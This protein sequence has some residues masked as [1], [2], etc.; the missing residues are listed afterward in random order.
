MQVTVMRVILEVSQ[1]SGSRDILQ[2]RLS[3]KE[4]AWGGSG[5]L[6]IVPSLGRAAKIC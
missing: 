5:V 4:E 6:H 3:R 2:I 1:A